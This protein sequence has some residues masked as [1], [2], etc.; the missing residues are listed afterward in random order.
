MNLEL[1]SRHESVQGL[2][3]E[4]IYIRSV[5]FF[6]YQHLQRQKTAVLIFNY[7][8]RVPPM[9]KTVLEQEIWTARTP[10]VVQQT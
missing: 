10:L 9:D 5:Y 2:K 7:P 4:K 6:D 8:V 1:L 3:N